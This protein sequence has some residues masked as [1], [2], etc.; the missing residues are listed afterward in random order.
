MVLEGPAPPRLAPGRVLSVE[1]H[2]ERLRIEAE[3]PGDGLLVVNDAFWPGWQASVDGSPVPILAADGLVRAVPWPAGRHLLEMRYEPPEVR[4][5]AALGAIGV[6]ALAGLAWAGRRG[7][8]PM[9]SG[10][11]G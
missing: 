6:V 2:P 5:G 9:G 4:I 10:L 11:P 1:R 3:S 7:P 8:L